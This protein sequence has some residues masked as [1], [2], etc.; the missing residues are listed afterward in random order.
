MKLIF[1]WQFVDMRS[2]LLRANL[3]SKQSS[4]EYSISSGDIY[5]LTD[6]ASSSNDA[7]VDK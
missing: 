2:C 3:L 4:D 5:C 1:H 6:T 7:R